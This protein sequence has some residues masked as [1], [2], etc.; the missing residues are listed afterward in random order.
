MSERRALRFLLAVCALNGLVCIV[1]SAVVVARPTHG[2]A[3]VGDFAY[4]GAILALTLT[5]LQLGALWLVLQRPVRD[6]LERRRIE[7]G[8]N[9]VL[10]DEALEVA[11]QPVV[12]LASRRIVGVEA[13]A[14][15]SAEP[16]TSPDVWF[17]RAERVGRG[18][19]LELLAV[20]TALETGRALPEHLNI[21]VNVSP[22]MMMSPTL[23]PALLSSPIPPDR[24]IIEITEHAR[25]D[26]YPA[27][28]VARAALRRVGIRVAIDDAGSGYSTF[29][30]IV[31]LAPDIIKIDR[32]LIQGIDHDDACRAMVGSLV[33]YALQSGALVV[34]EGVE[35]VAELDSLARLGVDAVQGYL[36]G[37]P[38]LRAA[39]WASWTDT[40][41]SSL[42]G[43]SA[44]LRPAP[45]SV[46][47][48]LGQPG[49]AVG[50]LP[51]QQP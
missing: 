36:L 29:R 20:R 9:R 35:T 47:Q 31:T 32:T 40:E 48:H 8:V 14:R 13:L 22:A 51:R 19:E 50:P 25:V 5:P 3:P 45:L 43:L 42:R 12:H 39:D 4:I 15:F 23:L 38:T 24:I 49:Q 16:S 37:R 11:F 21:A 18:L 34:G 44:P 7:C 46:G 2:A 17:A 6:M 27:L 30:H 28:L 10:A 33:L 1:A 26:D 41:V